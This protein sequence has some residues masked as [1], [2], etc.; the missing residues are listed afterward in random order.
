MLLR[1]LISIVAVI[2]GIVCV[3]CKSGG[4]G[5]ASHKKSTVASDP[6]GPALS[7]SHS[8]TTGPRKSSFDEGSETLAFHTEQSTPARTITWKPQ[9]SCPVDGRE[10]G[11]IGAPVTV[12]LEGEPLFV[13]SQACAKKAQK[14]PGKYLA[15]V[16]R[17]TSAAGAK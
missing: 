10:L 11:G 5:V 4:G 16:R 14:E 8:P 6:S 15:R 2:L 17:E 3:G 7:R 12:T 9:R 1:R 13:C